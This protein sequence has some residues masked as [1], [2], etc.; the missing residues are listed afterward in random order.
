MLTSAKPDESPVAQELVF[1]F[2]LK[3]MISFLEPMLPSNDATLESFNQTLK[4]PPPRDLFAL[5]AQA[6]GCLEKLMPDNKSIDFII[7][8]SQYLDNELTLL[9]CFVSKVQEQR[10]NYLS[11][12]RGWNDAAVRL[13]PILD[14]C[15]AKKDL[16]VLK[17]KLLEFC[18]SQLVTMT[19]QSKTF[20]PSLEVIAHMIPSNECAAA[21]SGSLPRQAVQ[22]LQHAQVSTVLFSSE[23]SALRKEKEDMAAKIESL[24]SQLSALELENTKKQSAA[25]KKEAGFFDNLFG[26]GDSEEKAPP[27]V[28]AQKAAAKAPGRIAPAKPVAPTSPATT[29]GA[30]PAVLKMDDK[31]GAVTANHRK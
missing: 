2:H 15:R 4:T 30:V 8:F 12:K 24:S 7:K 11:A 14:D 18:S 25:P 31:K 20:K 10:E 9:E 3:K 23:L 26:L 22:L 19:S 28:H 1:D 17:T 21:A 5:K 13:G 16:N 6:K 27:I 29:P